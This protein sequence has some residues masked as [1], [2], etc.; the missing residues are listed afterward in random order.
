MS[1]DINEAERP[2]SGPTTSFSPFYC[3]KIFSSFSEFVSYKE[4]YEKENFAVLVVLNCEK[5]PEGHKYRETLV[6][7]KVIYACKKGEKRHVSQVKG[8]RP[9]VKSGKLGCKFKLRV[10]S[11][12]GVLQVKEANMEYTNHILSEETF[13]HLPEQL[14]LNDEELKEAELVLRSGGNK[15]KIAGT[16]NVS[17]RWKACKFET[18]PQFVNKITCK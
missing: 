6:Y 4:K 7:K 1:S 14:R 9:N 15:K 12:Q 16:L 11:N 17:K 2:F 8:I 10:T 13:L 5:W 18:T 3:G